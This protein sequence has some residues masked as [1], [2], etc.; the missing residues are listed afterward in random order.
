MS[1]KGKKPRKTKHEFPD[2]PRT[3]ERCERYLDRMALVLERAGD[4]APAFL[5]IVRRL[6]KELAEAKAEEE[7]LERMRQRREK[8]KAPLSP[9]PPSNT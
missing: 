7:I 2:L 6:E 3:V 9:P 1:F 4:N 8:A 5:P